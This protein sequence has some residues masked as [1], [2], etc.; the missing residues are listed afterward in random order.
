MPM[1]LSNIT[2]ITDLRGK[3]RGHDLASYAIV[4]LIYLAVAKASMLL[5]YTYQTSPALIWPPVGIALAAVYMFG[6]RMWIPIFLAQ[7][8]AV[9][10]SLGVYT[11][12][13]VIAA[14]YAIQAVVS[15][16]ALRYFKVDPTLGTL[17]SAL[18]FVCIA[19]VATTIEP[20]IA[21]VWQWVGHTLTVSPLLNF[22][23]AWTAGIFSVLVF[24]SL[25]LTWLVPVEKQQF[26][27]AEKYEL[28][29]A[30][31]VLLAVNYFVFWT[32]ILQPVGISIIFF[33]PA[34]LM[35]FTLRFHPRWLSFAILVT[36]L[37]GV[38]GSII[39]RPTPISLSTQLFAD[40]MYI[41]LIAAIFYIFASLVEE[42][43]AA[44][45]E[46][47]R[48]NDS[49][50]TALSKLSQEDKA[51]SDFIAI[52]A[53]EL[54][55]PLS[56][57]VSAHE[58]LK[59]QPQTPSSLEAL[60]SAHQ[61]TRMI[62]RLLDDLLDIARV[63]QNKFRL[64]K[65]KV[66]LQ[67]IVSQAVESSA[68]FLKKRQHKLRLSIP[69]ETV[70]MTVDPVRLKQILINLLNNAGKYTEPGGKIELICESA[71]NEVTIMVKDTGVGLERSQMG[72]IFEPFKQIRTSASVGT[73]LGIG[74]SITKRLV[75]MHGGEIEATSD[76]LGRGSVFTVRM[77]ISD[78][79][80]I[81]TDRIVTSAKSGTVKVLII[82]DNEPAANGLSKLLKH[83]GHSVLVAY[84]GEEGLSATSTF[85]PDIVL[86]D[87]GLPDMDGYEVSRRL[88]AL[89][90][91]KTI[92]AISG[93]GQEADRTK[94]VEAGID[95]YLTK[96]VAIADVVAILPEPAHVA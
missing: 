86:L 12:S 80:V 21:T 66:R 64:Q 40:E 28:S 11:I 96:P 6:N 49:L 55:N 13:I 19:I 57:I 87:I 79:D 23:R 9:T 48:K 14:A 81:S 7:I 74:L 67:D 69:G 4:F 27:R 95:N 31:A 30:I 25:I 73:G 17:R 91:K 43:K 77:P 65:E 10:S 58:W 83:L 1:G 50:D 16:N 8:V 42:R 56:P 89:G 62:Q 46:L 35:W 61:N 38:A 3:L 5:Y 45:V 90:W 59:M 68:D 26:S 63:S 36:S 76:G 41:G 24:G 33:L 53:H 78:G 2:T 88:R 93:Y 39:G 20:A 75:E 54:R 15:A 29:L 37:E 22:A 18:I 32:V 51:K 70:W 52:L 85:D 34:V 44:F 71:D 84:T 92:T 72:A 82:D 47:K 60:E 94:A